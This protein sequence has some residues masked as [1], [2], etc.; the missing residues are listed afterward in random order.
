MILPILLKEK[1]VLCLLI[2]SDV[3]CVV[4][5]SAIVLGAAEIVQSLGR[6]TVTQ[7]P[8]HDR[9]VRYRRGDGEGGI[10]FI[11]FGENVLIEMRVNWHAKRSNCTYNILSHLWFFC[12][13]IIHIKTMNILADVITWR[14]KYLK[15]Y[16]SEENIFAVIS[17]NRQIY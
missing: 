3:L 8:S 16:P 12:T 9:A 11:F 2:M 15:M 13:D 6:L 7:N 14:K 10:C 4:H 1:R 5:T 17:R